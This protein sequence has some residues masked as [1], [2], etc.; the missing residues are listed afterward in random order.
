MI[1]NRFT[2]NNELIIFHDH[3]TFEMHCGSEAE[4]NTTISQEIT[5][6][7]SDFVFCL[8]SQIQLIANE[9]IGNIA[10]VLCVWL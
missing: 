8:Y 1:T 5:L 9:L 7:S 4:W 6:I 2:K 3:C 10:L